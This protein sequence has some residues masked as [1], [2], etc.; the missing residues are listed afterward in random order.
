[1]TQPNPDQAAGEKRDTKVKRLTVGHF[2][3]RDPILGGEHD[4]F[5]VVV[6]VGDGVLRVRPLAEHSVQVDADGFSPISAD[7]VD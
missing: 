5:G 3:H 1:M 7:D 2:K 4:R 6:E